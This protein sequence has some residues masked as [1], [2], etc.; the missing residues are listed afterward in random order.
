VSKTNSYSSRY[1]IVNGV[2]T[3]YVEAGEGEAVVLVHGAGPG[4]SGE[5]GWRNNIPSLAQHFR[6]LAIDMLGFG[7]T[8][9]PSIE[10]SLEALKNHLAGFIRTLCLEPVHLVGNSV[11]AYVVTKCALDYPDLVKKVLMVSTANVAR[12]MGIQVPPTVASADGI[13]ALMAALEN[14]NKETMRKWM[15]KIVHNADHITD[16]LIESRVRLA[17]LPGVKEA[18]RSLMSYMQTK[19]KDDPN[20]QQL[21]DL[22]SRLPRMTI[23]LGLIWGQK[24]TFAPIGYGHELKKMLPNMEFHVLENSGHQCQS[25]EI[26]RFNELALNFL[27]K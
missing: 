10:Y 20:H 15:S 18:G 17:S 5:N 8:D 23:P 1:V 21:Y 25:D 14:P 3:H 27:W 7:L 26:E 24:D 12:A 4:A 9:K 16:T 2:R 6:V 13:Q 22:K 11:G 19:L